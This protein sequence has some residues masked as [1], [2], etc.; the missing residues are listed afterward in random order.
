[1]NKDVYKKGLFV[2][3]I[4]VIVLIT[5]FG[6]IIEVNKDKIVA[7]E[8]IKEETHDSNIESNSNLDNEIKD[9]STIFV[10]I[11]GAVK[12][13]GIYELKE[14]QRLND[15]IIKAGGFTHEANEEYISKYINKARVLND[16]EKI[17]IPKLKD[18]L[19]IIET[20]N[21]ESN[22]S[23][24]NNNGNASGKININ[25]A[26]KVQLTTLKG[27]GETYAQRIID[28]RKD[29]KFNSIEEIKNVKG[30]GEKTFEVIKDNITIE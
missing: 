27:I 16:E 3:A 30:I 17:Y 12:N 13:P 28:Y 22:N 25:S 15:A 26:S 29:K 5:I 14:G 19:S 24:S 11:N 9:V 6:Y 2:L 1:M 18:D 10:D 23:D 7:A 21:N 4:I 8:Q 20:N